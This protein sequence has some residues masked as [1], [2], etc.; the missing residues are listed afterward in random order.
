MPDVV[1]SYKSDERGRTGYVAALLEAAGFDVWWDAKLAAG[2]SYDTAILEQ[3]DQSKCLLVLWSQA[4]VASD[5]VRGEAKIADEGGKLIPVVLEPCRIPPP[6]N[7][8]HSLELHDWSG[9]P[10]APA[11]I[12]VVRSIRRMADPEG[13]KAMLVSDYRD[14]AIA[15]SGHLVHKLKAKDATGRWAYYFVL[16]RPDRE[17]EFMRAIGGDGMIDLETY[18]SVIAS[19]Y[20]EAPSAELRQYLKTR[21]GFEV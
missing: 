9:D 6:F 4:A 5:W 16:V 15:R 12:E 7:M 11:W 1:I 18:G 8:R 3:I 10:S 17:A 19:C 14:A 21:F 2:R 20:G 13:K